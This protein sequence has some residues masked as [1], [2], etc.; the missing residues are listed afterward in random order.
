M[1]DGRPARRRAPRALDLTVAELVLIRLA[2]LRDRRRMLNT[3]GM[4]V[5]AALLTDLLAKVELLE[6]RAAVAGTFATPASDVPDESP[7]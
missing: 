2:L 4:Q 1:S 5:T 6:L 7:F 3:S